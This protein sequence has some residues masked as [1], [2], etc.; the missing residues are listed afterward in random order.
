MIARWPVGS[1]PEC[2]D[3]G[4]PERPVCEPHGHELHGTGVTLCDPHGHTHRQRFH[5]HAL[6]RCEYPC[7]ILSGAPE[8]WVAP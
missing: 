5:N 7:S 4:T 3:A 1:C 8:P 6:S 2:Y